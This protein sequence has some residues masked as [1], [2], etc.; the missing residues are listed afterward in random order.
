MAQEGFGLELPVTKSPSSAVMVNQNQVTA[1]DVSQFLDT[2]NPA[3][4]CN[5]SHY[6][7]DDSYDNWREALEWSAQDIGHNEGAAAIV[8]LALQYGL[9]LPPL[10]SQIIGDGVGEIWKRREMMAF[11]KGIARTGH[12]VQ[13][14]SIAIASQWHN[15]HAFRCLLRHTNDVVGWLLS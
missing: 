1:A 8:N 10:P 6:H 14:A 3:S 4:H 12:I 11:A 5:Q 2:N 7:P 15:C 13:A 9:Q